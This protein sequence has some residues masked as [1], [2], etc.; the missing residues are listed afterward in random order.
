MS[1]PETVAPDN[2]FVYSSPMDA[3][4]DRSVAED[5]SLE[6]DA[7][8][9][10]DAL[11]A[12][13]RIHAFRDR[14]RICCFDVSV[15]QCYALEAILRHGG[16]T[17]NGLAADLYLDKST[18]SRVVDGLER[19]GYVIRGRDPEDRRSVRLEATEEGR[20]LMQDIRRSIL[21]EEKQL[22]AGFDPEVRRALPELLS[23]LARAAAERVEVSG[24]SCCRIP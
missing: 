13:I 16:L 24:G 18:A 10:Y 20:T 1:S 23:M 15:S 2:R 6:R 3:T 4:S 11:S 5:P 8:E 9:L 22:L 12:L 17:V 19:K 21:E 7:A 14:D